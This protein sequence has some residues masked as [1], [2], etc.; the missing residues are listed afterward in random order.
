MNTKNLKDVKMGAVQAKALYKGDV[1]LWQ[2]DNVTSDI[3]QPENLLSLYTQSLY[4]CE[5]NQQNP[6]ISKGSWTDYVTKEV[7][8][9]SN[10]YLTSYDSTLSPGVRLASGTYTFPLPYSATGSSY[11][12]FRVCTSNKESAVFFRH[13]STSSYGFA[14][15]YSNGLLNLNVYTGSSSDYETIELNINAHQYHTFGFT[16][17]GGILKAYVDG[18]YVTEISTSATP[19]GLNFVSNATN[20]TSMVET[21]AFYTNTHSESEAKAVCDGLKS[22]YTT[23]IIPSEKG[24]LLYDHGN[25][26]EE[27]TGGWASNPYSNYANTIC[28]FAEDCMKI[29]GY[30][31]S[32]Y[33]RFV[34][35]QTANLIDF[36]PYT[37]LYFLV[38][39]SVFP[40]N[41]KY[42]C[43]VM[44]AKCGYTTNTAPTTLSGRT[45]C[46]DEVALIGGKVGQ[47][48]DD[49]VLV[50]MDISA[51]TDSLSVIIVDGAGTTD[52]TCSKVYK[53]WLA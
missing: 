29:N 48:E 47:T 11:V 32:S 5:L 43:D 1:L 18:E 46:I 33:K 52:G 3:P 45:Y 39:T 24:L 50:C 30:N 49:A 25:L 16:L 21:L 10:S 42:S 19:S 14:V 36:T 4:T 2:K 17:G 26:C 15:G 12:R 34:S 51:I 37:K 13:I 8:E 20:V 35:V 28:E 9:I 7:K 6:V 27:I 41:V 44:G 31:S 53:V 38:S 40:W 23:D 22:K